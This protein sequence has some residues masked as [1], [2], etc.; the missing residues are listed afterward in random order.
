[1]A[2]IESLFRGQ[3]L[4]ETLK[5]ATTPRPHRQNTRHLPH[6]PLTHAEVAPFVSFLEDFDGK[7][8]TVEEARAVAT[9]V[10]KFLK[11]ASPEKPNWQDLLVPPKVRSYLDHLKDSGMCGVDGLADEIAA[12][13]NGH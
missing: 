10:S 2:T 6:F 5:V 1:M 13:R 12:F 8:K 7:R 4:Q 11:F 9:D 3:Q